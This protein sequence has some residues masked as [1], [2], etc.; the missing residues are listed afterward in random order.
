MAAPSDYVG[1]TS[2]RS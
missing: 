1:I 2:R